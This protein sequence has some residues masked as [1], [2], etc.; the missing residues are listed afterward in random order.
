MVTTD[1]ADAQDAP[2]SERLEARLSK[3]QKDFLMRAAALQGRNLTEFVLASAYEA[4]ER[5]VRNHETIQ[6]TRQDRK[7]LVG[8]LLNPPE[9]SDR[10]KRAVKRHRTHMER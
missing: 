10:L 5:T 7:T 2:R 9:P 8:A 3:P 6:L 4:A 1:R